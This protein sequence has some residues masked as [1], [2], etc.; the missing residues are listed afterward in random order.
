MT[1]YTL[2][3]LHIVNREDPCFSLLLQW[4]KKIPQTNDVV[5]FVGDVFDVWVG[6]L[7]IFQKEYSEFLTELNLLANKGVLFHY[8]E[9][10]HDFSLENVFKHKGILVHTGPHVMTLQ[11][12]KFYFGH[13]D[14]FVSHW[15]YRFIH[16]FMRS[17]FFWALTHVVPQTWVK[18]IGMIWS[19][20]QEDG[21]PVEGRKMDSAYMEKLRNKCRELACHYFEQNFYA[22]VFGH[23]HIED[24]LQ[25]LYGNET[26]HYVNSGFGRK[27]HV[28][29]KW[30]NSD[31][32]FARTT[33]D[34]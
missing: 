32:G 5:V 27:T 26:C 29:W 15:S 12:K 2:S 6:D 31:E 24:H 23:F 13:G 16:S 4:L 34:G 9:G 8:I 20:Y 17:G 25:V 28:V 19:R 3:D 10:N 21:L 22:V 11:G 33:L 7:P 30:Q 14:E 1:L 18:K